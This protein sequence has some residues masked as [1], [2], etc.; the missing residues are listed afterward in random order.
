M[1]PTRWTT[2]VHPHKAYRLEYPADWE[3]R[4]E[5]DGRSCGFGP[6]ERDDVGLWISVMPFS[7]DTDRLA[8]ELPKMF[9]FAL[10]K[11]EAGAVRPDSSLR[12]H[13]MKADM[14]GEGDG[15]N[16]WILA[17]GDLVLF[18]SSQVP[19]GERDTWNPP[20]E[21]LMASVRITRDE[22]LL[23][24]QVAVET[25]EILRE[26][27]PEQGYELEEQGIRGRDHVVFLSN[28]Y[29]EVKAAPQRRQ[30]IVRSFVEGF[31]TTPENLFTTEPFDEVK[32][33]LLPVL[34]PIEYIRD[35][36]PTAHMVTTDWLSGVV[37]VYALKSGR[38]IR[39]VTGW[40]VD[41]W[42][43]D[44]DTL[45]DQAIE[46][47]TELGFPERLE[48]SRDPGGG[49]RVIL[50]TTEDCFDASRLLH[51]DL[52]RIFSGPLGSP[53]LAGVPDRD[54]LVVFS[55]RKSV[56]RR[57]ARQVKK[58]HDKSAYPITPRLFLVTHDGIALA[59]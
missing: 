45:H 31:A 22:E 9:E 58:D 42:G 26:R 59:D 6:R 10:S 53:F 3:H 55:N 2:F 25:L 56:R 57:I 33:L 24:R 20:F 43:I 14:T 7:L 51:P 41:R 15:G 34:K 12:H 40:D 23:M 39:F 35:E 50:I 54:T 1:T 36:G 19:A 44:R 21:R 46:N 32:H 30:E 13:G 49:G 38:T 5:E 18:A 28:L 29:R 37:V 17:G 47:I 48:G 4:V 27:H 8:D 16:Y 11:A 52:H